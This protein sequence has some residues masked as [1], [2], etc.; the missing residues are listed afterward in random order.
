MSPIS[1]IL[2]SGA[3]K[4]ALGSGGGPRVVNGTIGPTGTVLAGS[5]FTVVRNS[6][7]SYTVTFT[8]PFTNPPTVVVAPGATDVQNNAIYV[9]AVTINGFTATRAGSASDCTINFIAMAVQ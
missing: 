6:A 9:T 5:G 2:P 8:T 1:E 4:E 3:V 7:G